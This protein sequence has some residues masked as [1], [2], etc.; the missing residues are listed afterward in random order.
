MV[1]VQRSYPAPESLEIEAQKPNGSYSCDDVVERLKDD[2][3][4]KCY[5]CEI[6]QLQ[7]PQIEHL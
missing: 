5:I 3:H 7:D 4:N 2:F 1:K 6:D